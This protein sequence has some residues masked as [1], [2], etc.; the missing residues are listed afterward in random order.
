MIQ[1][2][3][4]RARNEA[5]AASQASLALGKSEK[6]VQRLKRELQNSNEELV[7]LRN[8]CKLIESKVKPEKY[9]RPSQ[10]YNRSENNNPS[11]SDKATSPLSMWKERSR[12]K[13]GKENH[14]SSHRDGTTPEFRG[15]I[16]GLEATIIHLRR[17]NER[18]REEKDEAI[19]NA[20]LS[21][22][23]SNKLRT[24]GEHL[25]ERLE[26][27]EFLLQTLAEQ[28]GRLKKKPGTANVI[29]EE[30]PRI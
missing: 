15:I 12:Y 29:I 9:S 24:H 19:E 27:T 25:M 23:R 30:P 18:L 6:E 14:S 3:R 21:R 22:K 11:H 5:K 2:Q 10:Q 8:R 28:V 16:S 7:K 4:D 26:Q 13:I 1:N 20:E 17:Q